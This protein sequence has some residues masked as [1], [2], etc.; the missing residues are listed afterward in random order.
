MTTVTYA[1][2]QATGFG[3][4]GPEQLGLPMQ[5]QAGTPYPFAGGNFSGSAP[6][7]GVSPLSTIPQLYA[8]QQLGGGTQGYPSPQWSPFQQPAGAPQTWSTQG[9]TSPAAVL[10]AVVWLQQH[11]VQQ[12]ATLV[13]LSHLYSPWSAFASPVSHPQQTMSM[14]GMPFGGAAGQFARPGSMFY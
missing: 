10:G 14:P 6:F 1:P 4:F 5:A 2:S 12:L 9:P 3:T 7:G 8:G 11:I 13:A